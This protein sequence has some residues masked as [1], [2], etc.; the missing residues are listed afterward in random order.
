MGPSSTPIG[1]ST[2][3]AARA[4]RSAPRRPSGTGLMPT[5]RYPTNTMTASAIRNPFQVAPNQCTNAAT[6]RTVADVSQMTRS[7]SRMLR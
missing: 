2:L 4:T 6:T 1:Y 3:A 5:T 7:S